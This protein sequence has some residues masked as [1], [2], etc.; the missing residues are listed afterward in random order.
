MEALGVIFVLSTLCAS[1]FLPSIVVATKPHPAKSLVVLINTFL[2]WTII[3]WIAA[4]VIALSKEGEDQIESGHWMAIQALRR[5]HTREIDI[6]KDDHRKTL[7][8]IDS[9]NREEM[10]KLKSSYEEQLRLLSTDSLLSA[11][12][13]KEQI[14]PEPGPVDVAQDDEPSR[15]EYDGEELYVILPSH[16]ERVVAETLRRR[17]EDEEV[18]IRSDAGGT[19]VNIKTYDRDAYGPRL[20]AIVQCRLNSHDEIVEYQHISDLL[21]ALALQGAQRAYLI[22]TS[23]FSEQAREM[24]VSGNHLDRVF[25]VDGETFN[26]WRRQSGLAPVRYLPTPGMV[27]VGGDA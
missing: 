4:L 12:T 24:L 2:G 1:Y 17:F 8:R 21:G 13:V 14:Q 22:T 26:E 6:I 3:G 19:G 18:E 7:E 15:V 10:E 16:F 5:K 27:T 9:K 23:D 11:E 20:S 25:L